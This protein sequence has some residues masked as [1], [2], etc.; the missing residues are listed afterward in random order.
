MNK[1]ENKNVTQATELE[2]RSKIEK[3]NFEKK[4]AEI[5]AKYPNCFLLTVDD[6]QAFLK[7]IDRKVISMATSIGGDDKVKICELI[8][9]ACW[10][11]GDEAILN[12][13]SYFLGAMPQIQGLIDIKQSSLKKL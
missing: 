13:D 1:K 10:I 11:E 9:E 6:K 4:V 12:N 8:L 2:L 7:A 5:K 3:E